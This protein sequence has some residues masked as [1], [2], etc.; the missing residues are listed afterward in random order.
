MHLVVTLAG[1]LFSSVK[2]DCGDM[3]MEELVQAELRS[4]AVI[5]VLNCLQN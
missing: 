4:S 5:E 1:N 2:Q 3:L